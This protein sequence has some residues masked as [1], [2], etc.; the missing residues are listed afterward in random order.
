MLNE[1][2]HWI[3]SRGWDWIKASG[4]ANLA[5]TAPKAFNSVLEHDAFQAELAKNGASTMY[6]GTLNAQ[7]WDKQMQ[8]VWKDWEKQPM[9]KKLLRELGAKGEAVSRASAKAMWATRDVLYT[10]LIM[11]RMNRG[12]TMPE[13][14][15]N[16]EKHMPAYRIKSRV[17]GSRGLSKVMHDPSM[18]VFSAYHYGLL[19]SFGEHAKSVINFSKNPKEGAESL[20]QILA[21]AG[22]YAYLYPKLDGLY[23]WA[24]REMGLIGPNDKIES[25]RAGPAAV[26]KAVSDVMVDKKTVAAMATSFLTPT[27]V[28]QPIIELALDRAL[29]NGQSIVDPADPPEKQAMDLFRYLGT[30]MDFTRLGQNVSSGKKTLPQAFVEKA[31]DVSVKTEEA[32][33]KQQRAE[34]IRERSRRRRENKWRVLLGD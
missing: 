25:R 29:Y 23:T 14:I 8:G 24:G 12:E 18:T 31:L 9:Y 30:K 16:V 11:E 6:P 33:L 19:S 2:G 4:W 27:P 32:Q 15:K 34:R 21:L 22:T 7:Y 28:A 10:Q 20:G 5:K 1:G 3:P 26:I 17:L 13:A